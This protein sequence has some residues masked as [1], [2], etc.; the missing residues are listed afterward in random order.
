MGSF[1][2]NCICYFL[3]SKKIS[4]KLLASSS[5]YLLS[6]SFWG[7]GIQDQFRWMVMVQSFSW[8][9]N[10]LAG[11]GWGHLNAWLGKMH[12]QTH[13][14]DCWQDI[15]SPR[16]LT[17]VFILLPGWPLSETAWVFSQHGSWLSSEQVIWENPQG[18]HRIRLLSGNTHIYLDSGTMATVII[19]A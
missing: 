8:G 3:L 6:H 2:H 12:F 10:Q 4:P 7:L 19:V 13:S 18:S 17:E 15:V 14:C 11:R 5:K 16:L 1:V 9:C